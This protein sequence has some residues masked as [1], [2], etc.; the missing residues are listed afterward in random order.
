MRIGNIILIFFSLLMISCA[1]NTFRR[2]EGK[3]GIF[4]GSKIP[5]KIYVNGEL[6]GNTNS[7]LH[8][9]YKE[10]Q[11]L[12]LEADGYE[13]YESE[14]ETSLRLSYWVNYF[15]L[16]FAPIALYIDYKNNEMY[17]FKNPVQ[18]IELTKKER[19]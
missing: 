11:K 16:P 17:G 9:S 5:A 15:F 4:I 13:T 8:L 7:I 10:P 12:R 2:L 3:Q 1:T 14:I 19:R 6:K 18:Y